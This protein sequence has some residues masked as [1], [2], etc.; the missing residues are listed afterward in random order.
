MTEDHATR[1]ARAEDRRARLARICAVRA[2]A[3][4]TAAAVALGPAP[5]RRDPRDDPRR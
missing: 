5:S 3:A 2:L 4:V 1:V